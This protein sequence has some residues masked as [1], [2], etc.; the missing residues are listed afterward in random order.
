MKKKN[1]F[2]KSIIMCFLISIMFLSMGVSV[3]KKEDEKIFENIIIENINVGGLSKKEAIRKLEKEYTIKNINISFND[4]IW[5]IEPKKIELNYH[6]EDIVNIA[7]D[8]SRSD[9]NFENMKRIIKLKTNKPYSLK[10]RATYNEAELSNEVCKI[11]DEINVEAKDAV[12]QVLDSGE[13]KITKSSLGRFVDISLFKEEIYI[14]IN[15]KKIKDINLPVRIIYPK[16]STK[17]VESINTILG[18]FSTSFNNYTSR[19][20][21][22]HVAGENSSNILVMPE[23]IFSYNNATGARTWNNGYKSAPVIVGGK[24]VNG[25]GGGVCQVSTTIYNAALI[26]GMEIEEVHNH[27]FPSRYTSMGR[28]ATVSYGYFDLKFKNPFSHPIYIKNT[29]G[30]GC[31]TSSIYG[32]KDD[33][34]RLYINTETKY[35]K[36]KFKVNTYRIYLD[37]ENNIMRRELIN[38]SEYKPH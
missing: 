16:V 38:T 6:I 32:C 22:I 2:N 26:A 1:F 5:T 34:E 37:E 17:D 36:N 30:D 8:Y 35:L 18:Q 27:T 23:E 4:K 7:F 9:S 28:D 11:C 25:E 31:I 21:N 24:V 13:M 29:L 20:S 15:N 10:L 14:M 3:N 12:F 19:G 33:R